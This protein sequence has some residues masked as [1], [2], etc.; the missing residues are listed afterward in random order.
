MQLCPLSLL[1]L[2]TRLDLDLGSVTEAHAHEDQF[3]FCPHRCMIEFVPRPVGSPGGIAKTTPEIFPEP[4]TF[5][6][7]KRSV[8]RHAVLRSWKTGKSHVQLRVSQDDDCR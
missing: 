4:L 8:K 7:T 3:R 6:R 1:L 5:S 2:V